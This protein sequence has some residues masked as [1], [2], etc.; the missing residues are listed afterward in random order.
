M[1]LKDLQ[2]N[3][4]EAGDE[5]AAVF[6][7]QLY[8]DT[9]KTYLKYHRDWYINERFVRGDHWVVYNKTLNKIQSVSTSKGEVRRTINKIKSQI[10]G[11]KNF[12]KKSQPR[13]ESHPTELTDENLV[14][15]QQVNKIL[16]YIYRT[17]KIP[18]R[19]TD[20]II[21]GLKYSIGVLEG[22]VVQDHG[23]NRFEFWVDDTFDIFFDTF[24]TDVQSSRYIFKV[25]TKPL[26]VVKNNPLYK[27]KVELGG[28]SSKSSSDNI[29][30]KELL[31][32]EK[33]GVEKDG[34]SDDTKSIA[35]KELWTK[36]VDA[37]GDTKLKVFTTVG[38]QLVRVF[39]PQYRRYPFFVYS[40]E[41]TVNSIYNDAWIKDLISP[42]KSLD[43]T[44]SQI[45]SYIQRM[46]A[47]KFLIRQGVEVSSITD[48]GAEKIY[49]KGSVPP[50]PMDLQPLPST[51]FT[52][53]GN[54][55]KWIEELGGVREASLGRAPSSLQSGKALEALQS[56]DVGT[57]AEPIENLEYFLQEV[58]EFILELIHDFQITS[59][60]IF[61]Q[62]DKI[63]YIGGSVGKENIPGDTIDISP[64]RVEVKIVPE[65]SYDEE[66]RKE[67]LMRLAESEI[68]DIET[69]L[70]K[71]SISNVGDV[72]KR[73]RAKQEEKF[74]QEMT[75]QKE[76]HRTEGE[77]PADTADL[78]D[79]ENMQMAAGQQV[80]LTPQALWTPEHTQL[81]IKFIQESTDAYHQHGDIFDEHI[82]AE[83]QYQ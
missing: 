52:Y 54:T 10:R 83:E 49:Y 25:S 27:L 29:Q 28:G 4:I 73:V 47:G 63:K 12:V 42:N 76:S 80:P 50:K 36:Y 6:I 71:L 82:Q 53:V 40:P 32:Q 65:I 67:V 59:V 9:Y 34:S 66:N 30:Y 8:Q 16:Q 31:E 43:K 17:K 5:S 3:K 11:V 13:W 22:G 56:A 45:E 21:N 7:N 57:M 35:V 39:E 78:A 60:D 37:S 41:K 26:S 64:A 1:I 70:E 19:L 38:G 62:G 72:V 81:H 58:G 48:K 61:E 24:A 14:N 46:L 68:I 75:K 77:G 74:K 15:A 51:P 69:L 55:E 33:Q 23:N 20:V 2:N 18:L 44:V 79:Q